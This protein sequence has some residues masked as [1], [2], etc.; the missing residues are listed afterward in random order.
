MFIDSH[1]HLEGKRYDTDR[2]E[3]LARAKQIGIEA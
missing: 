1:A 3:V 2:A